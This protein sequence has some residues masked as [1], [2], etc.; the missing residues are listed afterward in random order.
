[1]YYI[2]PKPNPSKL[3]LCS[4]LLRATIELGIS[5]VMMSSLLDIEHSGSKL[6]M[7][8][9]GFT[10]SEK[11]LEYLRDFLENIGHTVVM[12][13]AG[14][15]YGDK[16][17]TYRMCYNKLVRTYKKHNKK[18]V[19][20]GHSLGGLYARK[21]AHESPEYIEQIISLGSPIDMRG[22]VDN[23]ISAVYEIFNPDF[24]D[25]EDK[26]YMELAIQPKVPCT[27]IYTKQDGIVH[28]KMCRQD[29]NLSNTVFQDIEVYGSH[30]GLICNPLVFRI[31][32]ELLGGK[33]GEFVTID[34][35][36][37]FNIF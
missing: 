13:G 28:W 23:I 5:K 3:L 14:R 18:L 10:G 32:I 33:S 2:E 22:R 15:N 4:D 24:R 6:I 16:P 12:W 31:L 25:D 20:I 17:E 36:K 9:P 21:L 7:L 30:I 35:S 19:L 34:N 8:L 1:M 11:S 26:K 27:H 37:V 29:K